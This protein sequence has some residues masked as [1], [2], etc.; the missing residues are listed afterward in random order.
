MKKII[1]A[2]TSPRRHGLLQQIG[3]EFEVIPSNYEEDMTMKMSASNLAK[4]L[5][6]GKAAEVAKRVKSGIVIGVDTFI[7]FKGKKI[8][9]PKTNAVA[10]KMLKLISGK[11]L[12][13]YSG[14]AMIDAATKQE[15]IDYEITKVKMHKLNDKEIESYIAT[16]EPLDKAGAFAVQGMGA[17][18]VSKVNGCYANAVGLPLHKLT[19]NLKKFGI[20]IFKYEKWNNS[21]N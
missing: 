18:F 5:A 21:M 13:I 14:I 6:Y 12:K 20:N 1:L 3:L 17:V 19:Q 15:L 2:S 7:S 8:G 11:T 4:T 9:K 10:R 16:G